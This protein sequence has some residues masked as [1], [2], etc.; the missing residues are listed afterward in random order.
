[1]KILLLISLIVISSINLLNAQISEDVK[2]IVNTFPKKI[3]STSLLALKISSKFKTDEDRVAAIYYWMAKNINFDTKSH[4]SDK[5]KATYSFRYKTQEEK[6]KK[7][8]KV[9]REIAE[10]VFESRKAVAKE[11]TFL[12][13][14]L[15][16]NA[17]IECVSIGGTSKLELRDIGRKAGRTNHYWN[18]VKIRGKW[19]LVDV[20]WGAGELYEKNE[21]YIKTYSEAYYL[22]EPAYFYLNHYPKDLKWLF[23]DRTKKDFGALPLFYKSYL[24]SHLLLLNEQ[25]VITS[26]TDNK[27]KLVFAYRNN[28]K[29]DRPYMFSYTFDDGASKKALMP[30]LKDN[31]LQMEISLSDIKQDYLT[32]Y[33]NNKPLVSF[34]IK[35]SNF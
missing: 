23:S 8:E 3:S 24:K 30:K 19:L 26:V 17:G 15:C 5:K 11:Y 10:D 32:V 18:A 20:T 1:M 12:F 9:N 31:K 27:L 14:K 25:G 33:A 7:I 34:K 22:I 4:F 16:S 29:P 35:R 6:E 21:F 13:K 28:H 2:Q